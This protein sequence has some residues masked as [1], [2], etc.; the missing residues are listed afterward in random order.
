M[1]ERKFERRKVKNHGVVLVRATKPLFFLPNHRA[2]GLVSCFLSYRPVARHMLAEGLP[3]EKSYNHGANC[4]GDRL[5]YQKE[6]H[7]KYAG[8]FAGIVILAGMLGITYW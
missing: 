6:S 2:A 7:R 5:V 3:E 1:G 4:R 8:P